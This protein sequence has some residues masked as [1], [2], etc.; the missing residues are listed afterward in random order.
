MR[1]VSEASTHADT[2][3]LT[4]PKYRPDIDGLRGIAV[5]A[6]IAFHAFPRVFR[7]GF[8]GVDI[9]FVISGF[10]ISSIVFRNLED[11]S[12][13]Y[14]EF[15]SR[16]IKR[17]FPA[18]IVILIPCLL[19]GWLLLP[20]E[21]RQLG[22]HVAAGAGFVS[23]FAFWKEAGYFDTT[24][25]QKPLLH[26]WSLGIEEQFYLIWPP[27]L[28][29]CWRKKLN[30]LAIT[31][32]IAF[33]SFATNLYLVQTNPDAAFYSPLSRFWELMLGGLL[34]YVALHRPQLLRRGSAWPS[35]AG[36]LL[37]ACG[38]LLISNDRAFP[39]WWALL[40]AGGT[41][42]TIA[43]G[44]NPWPNQKIL[45]GRTLV[46]F[47]LISYPLYLWHW[48]L[49]CVA[50]WLFLDHLK[51]V[52][53]GLVVLGTVGISILLSWLTY[54]FIEKPIR[55]GRWKQKGVRPLVVT[56]A[57]LV[58]AGLVTYRT[59][60][61]AFRYPG[62]LVK[63]LD[64][65]YKRLGADS[66]RERTCFLDRNQDF[67]Q[68]RGCTSEPSSPRAKSILLWGDSFAAH[69]YPGLVDNMD[70]HTQLTQFTASNC[71]P[72][73]GYVQKNWRYCKAIND[74]ALAWVARNH[75]DVVLLAANWKTHDWKLVEK[76]V[77]QLKALQIPSIYL[78]GPVPAWDQ[79]FP[80]VLFQYSRARQMSTVP[81]R[82][83]SDA[84]LDV[85]ELDESMNAFADRLGVAYLSPYKILCN[86]DGCLSMTGGDPDTVVAWD[87]SHLTRAGSDFVVASFDQGLLRED[88]P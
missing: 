41:F 15:Y 58:L 38:I 25:D 13:S 10:L 12:F 66:Y 32:L 69:L 61:F 53:A 79:P 71:P 50:R 60:G 82:V 31:A 49:L 52:Q 83:P 85:A 44:P 74:F 39:G 2:S 8:V 45:A 3:H 6:V 48:P 9:F 73:V 87:K 33:G 62:Q 19:F 76:T 17:I 21:F 51:G 11:Q 35:I 88:K 29:L 75:P 67:S 16:R 28:G 20:T 64:V 63:V 54:E 23:N 77:E 57:L 22:K 65:D 78:V 14:A 24:A 36:L 46:W 5:L 26:L 47:G 34:A 55:F 43:A 72:M 42:L 56:M 68:F 27:L 40:P 1:A 4:H 81:K 18:L 59:N 80:T 7:G 37:I 70:S 86:Q 84:A 30:F